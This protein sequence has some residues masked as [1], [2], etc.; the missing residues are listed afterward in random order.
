MPYSYIFMIDTAWNDYNT[1][2]RLL[3][4]SEPCSFMY[5]SEGN[6]QGIVY[7]ERIIKTVSIIFLQVKTEWPYL[8]ALKRLFT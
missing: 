3:Q 2:L 1:Q 7:Q 6:V 5:L 8:W 4:P